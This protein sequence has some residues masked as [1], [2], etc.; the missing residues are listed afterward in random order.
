MRR[1]GDLQQAHSEM[2]SKGAGDS[3]EED[4]LNEQ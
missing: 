3:L 2:A 1:G 4:P